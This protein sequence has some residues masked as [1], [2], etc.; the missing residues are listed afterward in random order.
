MTARR[1]ENA[2]TSTHYSET[3]LTT[4]ALDTKPRD[5]VSRGVNRSQPL[6]ADRDGRIDGRGARRWTLRLFVGR[7][8]LTGSSSSFPEP[9]NRYDSE[10]GP[11]TYCFETDLL[12]GAAFPALKLEVSGLKN[13]STQLG[14]AVA[15]L[16]RVGSG[17]PCFRDNELMNLLNARLHGFLDL[18]TVAVFLLAPFVF[19]L[20]GYVAVVAWALA[21]VHLLMTLLTSFP[22]G[23]L[24][25]IPFPIHGVVELVVGI[26][27]VLA[28][29]RWLAAGPGSPARTFFIGA[30]VGIVLVWILTRYREVP[31]A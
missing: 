3:L 20:G 31:P 17:P 18:V 8:R 2:C 13:P 14:R 19:G 12:A 4:R 30:G 11:T 22:L 9:A 15:H 23:L 6:R 21:V 25:V 7:L 26:V 29:P 24:K 1:L 28:M 16:R 5:E 10:L 27:L